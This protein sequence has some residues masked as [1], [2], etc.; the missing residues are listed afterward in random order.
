MHL[1]FPE[2]MG[3]PVQGLNDAGVENFQGAIDEYLSRECGQNTCDAIRKDVNTAR[4]EFDRMTVPTEQIPGFASL[5]VAL[6]ASLVKW[7]E[8]DKEREFF[9]TA[10]HLASR[11]EVDVLKISDYGTTGLTGEDEEETGRWFALVKSQGVSNKGSSAGG[12]FGIGKSSPFAASRFRTV[13]YG[14]RTTTGSVALQGVSRLVT[15]SNADGQKTQ[16]VG[17]IGHY[18]SQGSDSGGPV[19]RAVRDPQEIPPLFRRELPGTDIWVVGYRSGVTWDHDLVRSLLTNFWPA[20]HRGSVQFRVGALE[21][22]K[23]N[24]DEM[25]LRYSVGE[26]FVAHLYFKAI[27]SQP[28]R[29]KLRSVGDCELYLTSA[30]ADLPKKICMAR[31]SGMRIYDYQP[32]ACRVPFSGLFLC[33]DEEGN[34]LLRQL[35]PPKH[36]GWD[37]KRMEDA[38]GK[39]ALDEIKGWIRDEVKKLN[40]LFGGKSFN[41]TELA[42]YLPDIQPDDHS[43]LLSDSTGASIDESLE[44]RPT[45]DSVLAVAVRAKSIFKDSGGTAD[46]GYGKQESTGGGDHNSGNSGKKPRSG[47]GGADDSSPPSVKVRSYRSAADRYEMVIRSAVAYSGR[48]IVHAVGEDGALEGVELKSASRGTSDGEG[49]TVGGGTINGIRLEANIPLR[50]SVVIGALERR[51]LTAVVLS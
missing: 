26:D 4:L 39:R 49:L 24:L 46:G 1:R 32:R 11:D 9:E 20:I 7:G 27:A 22:S 29:K 13:F 34:K 21:I 14:T 35:E 19:F 48:L 15:H 17:F 36:D 45:L 38:S 40:P 10:V 50:L 23:E 2:L 25:I 8:K 51:S 44:P 33:S 37:Y 41:E 6:A 30:S 5:R 31:N 43:D 28:I 12:S 3:G 18:E 47:G 16:G 42:K